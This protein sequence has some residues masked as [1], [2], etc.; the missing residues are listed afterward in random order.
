VNFCGL[1][2]T[3]DL[4]LR[5]VRFIQLLHNTWGGNGLGGSKTKKLL[6]FYDTLQWIQ[7]WDE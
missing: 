5:A 7:L 3:C 2:P 1:L 4:V 6:Q